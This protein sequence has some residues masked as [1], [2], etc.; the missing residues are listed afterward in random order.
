MKNWKTLEADE[1]LIIQKNYS[2]GRQGRKITKLVIHHNAGN[3]STRQTQNVFNNNRQSAHYQVDING[4]IAQHVWDTDTAWHAGNWE[5]NLTS[6]GVE[7]ANNVS[8]EPWTVSEKTLDNGA[9]L[10]AA[11]CWVY[12][13]GRPAWG[14]NLFMHQDF[15][16]TRCPGALADQQKQA[17]ITRAQGYYDQL[18]KPANKVVSA[19]KNI[20]KPSQPSIDQLARDVIA[21]KYGN[22]QDR[23]RALG[24][25]Y[26]AVQKRVNQILANSPAPAY[27]PSLED[28]ADA[29]IRGEYGNGQERINRLGSKYHEVQK[30]VNRKLGY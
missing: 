2:I 4:K 3:L 28:L 21:G 7:H 26:N 19:V 27:E 12:Q 10:V 25:N 8:A 30:I 22:G 23:V 9:H 17:Y 14:V 24:A 1:N 15:T 6:I 16:R 13:L 11:L 29:V 20:V 18:A 5:A